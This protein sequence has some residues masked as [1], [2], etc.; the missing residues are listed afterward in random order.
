MDPQRTVTP[1]GRIIWGSVSEKQ[2]EGYDGKKYDPGKEPFQFGLAVLKSDPNVAALLQL[3]QST[4]LA[5]YPQNQAMHQRIMQEWTSGFT[6]GSFKFK[7]R[8]GDRPNAKTNAVNPNSQGCWV[9]NMSTGLPIKCANTMNQEIDPKTVE[10]GYFVDVAIS[11][12]GNGLTDGNAGIYINPNVVRLIA[13]GEKIIG[14]PSIEEAFKNHAAPSQLPPGASLTPVAPAGGIPDMSPPQQPYGAPPAGQTPG[15][16]QQ[17]Y[18]PAAMPSYPPQAGAPMMPG[19]QPGF[20]TGHQVQTPPNYAAP[21]N[22]GYP[23][24]G[25]PQQTPQQPYGVP[26][27]TSTPG[28][29]SNMPAG[30]PTGP[31]AG[32]PQQNPPYA[33]GYPINPQTGQPVM[34]HQQFLQPGQPPR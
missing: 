9:F 28:Y 15:Y 4:A 3:C 24:P 25:Y 31:G 22:A 10:R 34:P 23:S 5:S 12:N 7:I 16:P 30:F 1:V 14:G 8:D 11:I 19:G 2:T 27:T 29:P 6:I 13:F 32:Q 21:P 26:P 18:Q 20:P 33:T 17:P